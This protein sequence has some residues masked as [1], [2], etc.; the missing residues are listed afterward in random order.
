MTAFELRV[1]TV[2]YNCTHPN[3]ALI[4][5]GSMPASDALRRLVSLAQNN[6]L[7]TV[8]D[9]MSRW[10]RMLVSSAPWAFFD[11]AYGIS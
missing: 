10:Q 8:I 1:Q 4:P 11:L 3:S 7:G 6:R 5:H 2:Q 9:R